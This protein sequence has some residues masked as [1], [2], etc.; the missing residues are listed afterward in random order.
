GLEELVD[1]TKGIPDA[2]LVAIGPGND[3]YRAGLQQRIEKEGLT[4]RIR[5]P[6]PLP[7]AELLETIARGDV[8]TV[9]FQ[10]YCLSYYYS[11]P[12]K[13]FECMHAGLPVVTSNFPELMRLVDQYEVGIYCDPDDPS[14]IARSINRL[15]ANPPELARMRENT[16]KAAAELN[17]EIESQ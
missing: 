7:H 15:L 2:T 9:F 1:A 10:N 16:K 6:G 4:E 8:G 5:I 12:N 14:E 17:W 3:D 13:F 11:L